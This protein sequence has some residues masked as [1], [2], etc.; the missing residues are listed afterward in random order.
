MGKKENPVKS[1][2]YSQIEEDLKYFG[3]DHFSMDQIAKMSDTLFK[4]FVKESC[5]KKALEHLLREKESL[6]K[7]KN[8]YYTN[9]KMQTY[10]SSS[11]LT[12]R[13]KKIMFKLRTRMTKV[14]YNYGKKVLCPL[15]L[16][17]EDSQEEMLECVILKLQ[18]KELY[19]KNDEKYDDFFPQILT[20]YTKYR[21]FSK[22]A[23]RRGMKC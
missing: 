15:C 13:Q 3:L 5:K 2:W 8:N 11:K 12:I 16:N 10:L 7:I 20:K 18:C 17:H 21:K 19:Q 9:L 14:G 6:S 4:K 23:S 22:S 1:D